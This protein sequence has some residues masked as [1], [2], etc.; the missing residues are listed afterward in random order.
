MSNSHPLVGRKKM[1]PILFLDE[2]QIGLPSTIPKLIINITDSKTRIHFIPH[3]QVS[4]RNIGKDVVLLFNSKL[5]YGAEGLVQPLYQSSRSLTK[6]NVGC[7][8]RYCNQ[9]FPKNLKSAGVSHSQAN[10]K[11]IAITKNRAGKIRRKRRS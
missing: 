6:K 8:C 11:Q 1:H 7:K 4:I 9:T 2:L 10:G 3:R 5:K